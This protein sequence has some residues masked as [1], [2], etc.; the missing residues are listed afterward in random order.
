M[1]IKN[2]DFLNRLY[3]V[4]ISQ[5]WI[6]KSAKGTKCFLWD[7]KLIQ[8]AAI[9]NQKGYGGHETGGCAKADWQ[10]L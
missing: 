8:F 10:F 2:W 1:S 5:F 7:G 4:E 6:Q 3:R 9:Y